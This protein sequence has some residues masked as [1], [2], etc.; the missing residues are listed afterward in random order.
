MDYSPVWIIFADIGFILAG[1]YFA[2]AI[3]R[4]DHRHLP[5]MIAGTEVVGGKSS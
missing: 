1:I 2:M 3:F 4:K 5:D